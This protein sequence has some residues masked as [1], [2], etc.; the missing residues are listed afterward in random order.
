M[1]TN[2]KKDGSAIKKDA[3]VTDTNQETPRTEEN[4][5]KNS[6]SKVTGNFTKK[7]GRT[8]NAFGDGHEPGTIPGSGV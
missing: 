3:T 1:E 2:E 5:E 6:S 7:H 8:S 4:V